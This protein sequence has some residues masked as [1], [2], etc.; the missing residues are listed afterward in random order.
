MQR[1]DLYPTRIR[2]YNDRRKRPQTVQQYKRIY[3]RGVAGGYSHIGTVRVF[4]TGKHLPHPPFF[5]L[6][7]PKDSTF[8]TCAVRQHPPFQKKK[9]FLCYFSHKIPFF[10]CGP[11][12]KAR[13]RCLSPLFLNPPRHIYIPLSYL[14]TLG[15]YTRLVMS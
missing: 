8:S 14:S 7:A 10:T 6:A 5:A 13:G 4:A 1:L 2:G 11:V 9:M 12:L 3:T 15:I